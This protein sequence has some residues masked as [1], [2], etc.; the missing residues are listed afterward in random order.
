MLFKKCIN[1]FHLYILWESF[2]WIYCSFSL[3]LALFQ[4]WDSALF[5]S[6]FLVLQDELPLS[7]CTLL[8]FQILIHNFVKLRVLNWV[9]RQL[10][11]KRIALPF[12]H[13]WLPFDFDT[14]KNGFNLTQ[15]SLKLIMP[16]I[17]VLYR[18]NDKILIYKPVIRHVLTYAIGSCE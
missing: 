17:L 14:N 18:N 5:H 15:T 10:F 13:C 11:S 6:P 4:F 8:V 12:H 16:N 3:F 1:N 7:L 2:T 9:D